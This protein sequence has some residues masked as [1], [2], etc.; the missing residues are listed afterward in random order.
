MFKLLDNPPPYLPKEDN[1][2]SV[3]FEVAW[4]GLK[5][6]MLKNDKDLANG[7]AFHGKSMAKNRDAIT[8]PLASILKQMIPIRPLLT[9]NRKKEHSDWWV[10]NYTPQAK[11]KSKKWSN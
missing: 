6:N 10:I 8:N 2:F 9:V 3:V 1:P 7:K 4:Y 5:K 11:I